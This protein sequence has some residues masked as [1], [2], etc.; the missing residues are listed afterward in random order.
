VCALSALRESPRANLSVES[1]AMLG[2]MAGTIRGT[3]FKGPCLIL[4]SKE[5]RLRHFP[6]LF[7]YPSIVWSEMVS[8]ARRKDEC[9]LL[10]RC[11]HRRDD[12]VGNTI[13]S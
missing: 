6:P 9:P 5:V 3:I 1:T 8:S 11:Y 2:T 7:L 4:G 13:V 10:E 12:I